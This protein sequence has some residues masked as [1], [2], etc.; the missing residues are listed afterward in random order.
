VNLIIA[1]RPLWLLIL[2]AIGATLLLVVAMARW[3]AP[4]DEHAYWLAARRIIEGQPLYD[5]A[6]TIVTP[7]AYL[8]P[9][10]L[11]QAMVPIAAIVPSW[12]FSAG[13]TVL[14]GLALFW[15]AGRDVLRALALVAFPPVAVEFWFRNVHLFLAVLVVLGL[16]RASAS[17]AVGAAIKVSPILGIPYLALRTRWRE[18]AIATVV[19]LA[20]LAVSVLLSP[21]GWRAYVDF[22]LSVD[23]LQQSSFIA[24]PFPIR[25]L[26]GSAVAIVAARLPRSAGDP[27]LVVAVTLAL[28]SRGATARDLTAA[29]LAARLRA[30][31]RCHGR[32]PRCID[33]RPS[34]ASS[35]CPGRPA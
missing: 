35:S 21:D 13:W 1:K 4:S 29:G 3:G 28:P 30:A 20:M 16:R 31:S 25:A 12:L 27:L 7:F 17:F 34:S 5:P 14:M 6:A 22:A 9:P 19:G 18:A 15:L 33:P 10:P 32:L 11:A 26:A 24:V 23:P 8:Y 2:A